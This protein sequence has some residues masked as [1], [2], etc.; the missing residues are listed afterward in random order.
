MKEQWKDI[1]NYEGVYQISDLGNIKSLD[2][3]NSKGYNLKGKPKKQST[4][5]SGYKS[6]GLCKEGRTSTKWVHQLVAIAFLGHEPNGHSLVVDHEDNDKLNNRLDNLQI[7]TNRENTSKDRRGGSSKYVGVCWD[8]RNK[9]WKAYISINKKLKHLG[10][11]TEEIEAH[12]A[13]QSALTE[14]KSKDI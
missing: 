5:R 1:P 3:V 10:Y 4:N 12:N 14:L 2:R 7:F 8:K 9:K 13:Y 6:V 11:F